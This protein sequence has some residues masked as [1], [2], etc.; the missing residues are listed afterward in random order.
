MP[1]KHFVTDKGGKVHKRISENRAYAF[2]VVKHYRAET[3]DGRLYPAHTTCSWSSRLDL[4]Q[5]EVAKY[6]HLESFLEA[7][8]L[9]CT[10]VAT[11]K[12]AK[13]A[14]YTGSEWMGHQD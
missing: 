1:F 13:P 6:S 3:F 11:G 9:P 8:I 10:P 4:A 7:E 5:K 12:H 14:G 2:A